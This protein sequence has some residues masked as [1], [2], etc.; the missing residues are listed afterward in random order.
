MEKQKEN[1]ASLIKDLYNE[2]ISLKNLLN[3][4]VSNNVGQGGLVTA[5]AKPLI[6]AWQLEAN[7]VAETTQ[8]EDV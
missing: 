4:N 7:Q 6:P 3:S 8:D 1:Q 5:M 2:V